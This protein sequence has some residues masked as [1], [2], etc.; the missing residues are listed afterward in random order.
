MR[1]R[2]ILLWLAV[3][4]LLLLVG[5]SVRK[6]LTHN[7]NAEVPF[8]IDENAVTPQSDVTSQDTTLHFFL[9][10]DGTAL[11]RSRE[12]D[13]QAVADFI[14]MDPE[15][16][17]ENVR[18][19]FS[20][21]DGAVQAGKK[22]FPTDF[23]QNLSVIRSN[24]ERSGRKHFFYR[25]TIDG[26]PV[27]GATFVAHLQSANEIYAVSGSLLA[28]TD[29]QAPKISLIDSGKKA[30]EAA[31]VDRP[32]EP[33]S[34]RSN[35]EIFYNGKLTG[36]STDSTTYPAADVI[37]TDNKE[38]VV[39]AAEYIINRIDGSVL[40]VE[41]VTNDALNRT[42]YNCE[43][44]L[45]DCPLIRAEGASP[46]N[47][48]DVD[49]A[50]SYLGET[51]NY[52]KTKLNRDSYDDKGSMIKAFVNLTTQT[53]CPNALWAK[54]PFSQLVFCKGMASLDIIAHEFTHGVT[55]NTANL[56]SNKQSG[57]L[58]EAVSDVFAFAVD[59]DW[60]IGEDS[61]L[62]AIRSADNPPADARGAHP[63]R[64]FSPHYS[65]SGNDNGGIH[66]NSTVMSKA[67]YLMSEGGSF[68]GCNLVGIGKEKS[69]QIWYRALALYFTETTNFNYAY[70]SI[71]QACSDL[72][73]QNSTECSRVFSA[74]QA[75]EID[76]QPENDQT[77]AKCIGV[78]AKTPSC[79][80]VTQ[81]PTATFTPTPATT[82]PTPTGTS[83]PRRTNGDADCDN[84]TDLVDFEIWRKEY[85]KINIGR[86]ADFDADG[87]VSISDFQVW[88]KG[89][90][91]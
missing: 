44:G 34:I 80:G 60:M 35:K 61:T 22:L 62:G 84:D 49:G 28:K 68:N 64:L 2:T 57:A 1:S 90:F 81:I 73:G 14:E 25:Q 24:H 85:L 82:T 31:G 56:I 16:T 33:L 11:F 15:L 30:L 39:F 10:T 91:I 70:R 87:Q 4:F 13:M 52:F 76:Q 66:T 74:M 75:V 79:V 53:Q 71:L 50:Y 41:P 67:F 54:A 5:Q 8:T 12:A 21:D 6:T 77:G 40:Y 20:E 65:C 36:S 9:S 46:V 89:Y 19:L 59:P 83:C 43:G 29:A 42:I 27:F 55:E 37:V 45:T 63:D 51:Y 48:T 86:T 32:M 58:N 7:T 38:P 78:A 72:F 17:N 26:V 47:N 18:G 3:F 69:H 88:R 23:A